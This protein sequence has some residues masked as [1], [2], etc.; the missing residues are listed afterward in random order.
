MLL[1]REFS[2]LEGLWQEN[3]EESTPCHSGFV[4]KTLV[5]LDDI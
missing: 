4:G 1:N 3:H 5:L 2:Q